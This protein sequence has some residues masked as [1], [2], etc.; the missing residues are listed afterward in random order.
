[1]R[2]AD[3]SSATLNI[4]QAAAQAGVSAKMA[5]HYEALGLLPSIART[6]AGY[7]QYSA[8]DVDILCFIKR[9]RDLDFSMADISDLLKLW[10]NKQRTSSS[11]K[12]LVAV[13]VQHLEERIKALAAMQH[14]LQRLLLSCPGGPLAD[15]PILDE[16]AQ[17]QTG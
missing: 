8:Q 1:M 4:G 16:L 17:D 7:R 2:A 3:R 10:H 11:V 6:E 14:A 5:R 9:A 15:C 13:H 12:D